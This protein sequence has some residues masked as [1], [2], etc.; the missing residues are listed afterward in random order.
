MCYLLYLGTCGAFHSQDIKI[1][2]PPPWAPFLKGG[3]SDGRLVLTRFFHGN[4]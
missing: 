4:S 3:S 2:G 1:A